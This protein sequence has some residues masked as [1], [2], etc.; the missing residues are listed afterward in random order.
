MMKRYDLVIVGGGLVGAGLAC[1]LSGLG[2]SLALIDARQPSANDPRLFALNKSSC[3]FLTNL[4]LWPLLAANAAPIQQVHV[5]HQ[6]RFGAVRLRNSEVGV[7]SLGHVIPAHYIE[8]ALN[9]TLQNLPSLTLYRPALLKTLT[10]ANDIATLTLEQAGE[11]KTIEA[12]LVIGADGA[13]SF[14]REQ[15]NIPTQTFDYQQCAIVTRT[16]LQRSH[17]HIAYERFL[18]TGAIAMLPLY[19]ES[20]HECATIWTTEKKHADELMAM[21]EFEFLQTLQH[22]FGYRLGRLQQIAARHVFPLRMLR[23]EKAVEQN[24]LLLG[25]A[26]HTL[27]PIAAQG[28]NLALYE[29]AA[30]AD[31]IKNRL[32]TQARAK[33]G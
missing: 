26:L 8:T 28:F 27:H 31:G 15:A 2:L 14:V 18:K 29:V 23:A 21:T 9:N 30:L 32:A 4:G 33:K 3:Q 19:S 17:K 10:Q 22:E 5:S 7:S 13:E 16:T 11:I 1:S 20:K 24:V 6:G 12:S 25:N